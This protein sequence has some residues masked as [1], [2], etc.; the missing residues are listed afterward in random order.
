[1]IGDRT[2]N[3]TIV[4][5]VYH[6][7]VCDECRVAAEKHVLINY[8][9]PVGGGSFTVLEARVSLAARAESEAF[10]VS[11]AG[12]CN[13]SQWFVEGA[14]VPPPGYRRQLT[15]LELLAVAGGA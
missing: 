5:E 12:C 15:P 4:R 13:V 7:H 1:M 2:P 10:R 6:W 11:H 3:G 8:A 14:N 9:V